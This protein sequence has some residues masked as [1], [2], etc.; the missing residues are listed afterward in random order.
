MN[1][2]VTAPVSAH[3]SGGFRT[4]RRPQVHHTHLCEIDEEGSIV[5]TFCTVSRDSILPDLSL[6][7]Q[8]APTCAKCA[9]HYHRNKEVI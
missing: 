7:T 2:I 1:E 9:R 4:A 6:Y 5:R 8:R 3:A